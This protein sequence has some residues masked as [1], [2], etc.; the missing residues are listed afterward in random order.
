MGGRLDGSEVAVICPPEDDQ[1]DVGWLTRILDRVDLSGSVAVVLL[2]ASLPA[3]NLLARRRGQY[4]LTPADISATELLAR[5]EAAA[6]LQ[7]V[8]KHLR[9]DVEAAR[10]FTLSGD[11]EEFD[12]QM[13]LAARLQRDFLPQTMPEVGS[14][15]FAALFRP[16][17]WVSG[18][19]YDIF[20]LDE[21]RVGF[22]VA[23]VVGHGMPAALLTIYIKKSLQTKRILGHSYEIVPPSITLTLLNDDICQQ[24]LTSCQFCT[25]WYGIVDT[26]T[27]RLRFS[28]GGH[29]P[30]LL[31]GPG[32]S[33]R[34][35]DAA[36]PLLGVFP[37]ETF[38]GQEVTMTPGQRVVVF[39]DGAEEALGNE[40]D[41][42]DSGLV[43][44]C[45]ELL[46]L[47]VDEM[48]LQLTARIDERRADSFHG[49]DVTVLI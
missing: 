17:A 15:R 34:Q 22:Y 13:R 48:A 10:A 16:A 46:H 42:Q 45:R 35:L 25:A 28:R 47:P 11:Q 37:G 5:V 40:S 41:E 3:D 30:A 24:G 20:R 18:D 33:V 8:I 23:D 1:F 7:P 6:A 44:A 29:P 39:S 14:A 49:D 43:R 19:M 26:R 9:T 38:Q 12:E 36:G 4:V 31:I 2:P 21:H 27:L 32:K